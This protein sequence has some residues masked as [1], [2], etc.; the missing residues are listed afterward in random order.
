VLNVP[1]TASAN[2]IRERYRAL[3]VILHPD[4]QHNDRTKDAATMEFLE[5]QKAYEGGET[6][7]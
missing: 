4:K 1:V 7:V 2:E 3:S 5:L 6:F